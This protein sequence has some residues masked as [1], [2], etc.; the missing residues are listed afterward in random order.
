M[1]LNLIILNNLKCTK[2]YWTLVIVRKISLDY[3]KRWKALWTF[4]FVLMTPFVNIFFETIEKFSFY[5]TI[6]YNSGYFQLWINAKCNNNNKIIYKAWFFWIKILTKWAFCTKSKVH[7][8]LSL[9]RV[10]W[11]LC[12]SN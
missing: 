11:V 7:G 5:A 9:F 6:N 8:D 10:Q 2:L 4:D 3:K 12:N 1:I